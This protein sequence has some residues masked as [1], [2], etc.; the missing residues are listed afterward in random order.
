LFDVLLKRGK[1]STSGRDDAVRV[2]PEYG[3][4][5]ELS[6]M[7]TMKSADFI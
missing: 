4:P 3:L 7:S 2:M 5:I 6:N 1:G